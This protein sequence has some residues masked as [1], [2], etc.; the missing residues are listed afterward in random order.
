MANEIS[1]LSPLADNGGVGEGDSVY[2][3]ANPIDCQDQAEQYDAL[4]PERS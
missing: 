1:D 4:T 3:G 2:L